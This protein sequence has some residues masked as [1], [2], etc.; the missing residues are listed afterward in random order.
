M[1]RIRV[2]ARSC[3]SGKDKNSSKVMPEGKVALGL[4]MLLTV[5]LQR[6]LGMQP[7]GI[8]IVY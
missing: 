7:D 8:D 1:V 6:S 2:A 5:R 4:D 3:L